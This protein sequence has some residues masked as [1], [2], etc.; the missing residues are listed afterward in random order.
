MVGME[1]Q[2]FIEVDR[3]AEPRIQ[4]NFECLHVAFALVNSPRQFCDLPV[5]LSLIT[6]QAFHGAVIWEVNEGLANLV[7]F[8]ENQTTR[9]RS[10]RYART[11]RTGWSSS[12]S[13]SSIERS[14]RASFS[15]CKITS[16]IRTAGQTHESRPHTFKL[17]I[18]SDRVRT[19]VLSF[20]NVLIRC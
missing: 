5:D 14:S 3:V 20:E 16:H 15:C 6:F 11:Y 12:A 9:S 8:D 10:R 1:C 19:R 4:G 7:A 17:L 2:S 18:F 13:S